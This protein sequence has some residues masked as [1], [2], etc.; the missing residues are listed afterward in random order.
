MV[1]VGQSKRLAEPLR[2]G[3]R[4][5][6]ALVA[7]LAALVVAVVVVAVLALSSPSQGNESEGCIDVTFAS[8]LG[9]AKQHACGAQAKLACATGLGRSQ[10]FLSALRVECARAG[11]RFGAAAV[12]SSG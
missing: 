2:W 5:R 12:D 3:R 1:M 8:T 10:S 6:L 11:Y 4:E 7:L 9:G